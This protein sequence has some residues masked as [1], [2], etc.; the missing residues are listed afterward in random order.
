MLFVACDNTSLYGGFGGNLGEPEIRVYNTQTKTTSTLDLEEY[1]AG[2]VAGEVYNTWNEEA[3][4]VQSVLARTY[5]LKYI[6]D[7]PEIY[8]EKGI[9]T[10]IT[11]AQNYDT[12]TINDKIKNAVR[13][14]KGEVITHNGNLVNAYF[15]SN[16]GGKTTSTKSAFNNFEK[17]P[18]YIKIVT[19][20][21]NKENSKNYEWSYSFSKSEMLVALN[22]M[23]ISVSNVSSIKLGEKDES[24]RCLT[25]IIGSKEVSTNT[26]R[27]NL[28]TTKMRSTF[29]TGATI[30]GSNI[31]LSGLGYGHGVGVSQWGSQILAEQGK[32]YSE[33]LNY[34]FK[35]INLD[36]IY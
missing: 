15:H 2:V 36:K 34:Y 1:V 14:T 21:E 17:E 20:P 10:N 9:S 23:G 19:S 29:L 33:I 4:K 32:T 18:D 26:L 35:D 7:N 30:S 8:K 16:S 12:S 13:A 27:F 25:L 5:A 24:G 28:G 22:K 11:D 6:E 31:V 3:L